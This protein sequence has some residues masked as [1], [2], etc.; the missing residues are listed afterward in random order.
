[1]I[2]ERCAVCHAEKPEYPGFTAAPLGVVLDTEQSLEEMALQV[3]Q[4]VVVTRTM[5]LGNLTGMTDEERE[6]LAQWY[7]GRG[8][9]KMPE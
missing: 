5:P 6:L 7:A 8:Q 2:M 3:Y 9:S 4:S 1:V